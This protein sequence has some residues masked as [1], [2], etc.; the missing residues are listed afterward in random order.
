MEIYDLAL[1]RVL[2][3]VREVFAIEI[4]LRFPCARCSVHQGGVMPQERTFAYLGCCRLVTCRI[5]QRNSKS[6][7]DIGNN[8]DASTE[9]SA[10]DSSNRCKSP[11]TLLCAFGVQSNSEYFPPDHTI[12][13][14]TFHV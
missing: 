6:R 14:R 13:R 5:C 7:T 3:S 11:N 9:V 10:A 8:G 2:W 1:S 4:V 12:A